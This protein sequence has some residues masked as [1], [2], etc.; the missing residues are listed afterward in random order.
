MDAVVVGHVTNDRLESG[1]SPGGAV[2]YAGLAL[3]ALGARVRAIT[4]HGPEFVGVD[5]LASLGGSRVTACARTCTFEEHYRGGRRRARLLATA[6]R[7]QPEEVSAD[8]VLLGPVAGEIGDPEPWVRRAGFR[9][10]TL[11]GWLRSF[12]AQ[13]QM[14]ADRPV[15]PDAFRGF[16]LLCC[17]DEDLAGEPQLEQALRPRVAVMAVTLGA[18]GARVHAHGASWTIPS[19]PADE[20]DPTGA[21]DVFAA[22]LAWGLCRG[23]SAVLAALR[24]NRAGAW[25]VERI[26]L[27]GARRAGEVQTFEPDLRLARPLSASG[28]ISRG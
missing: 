24:A 7:L 10:A 6:E 2:L 22:V 27:E 26:G 3:Q 15:E 1:L 12:D 4:A 19:Y 16:D 8:L 14:R 11:Q 9:A 17:S 18:L 28:R 21:G 23:D 20:R 13:G 25:A 5:A